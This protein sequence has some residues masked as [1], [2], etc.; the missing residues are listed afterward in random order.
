VWAW[1]SEKEQR[2]FTMSF[3]RINQ[4]KPPP[5]HRSCRRTIGAIAGSMTMDR[6]INQSMQLSRITGSVAG[7]V[8][9]INQSISGN[10][11]DP[12]PVE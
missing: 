7:S 5:E 2:N 9:R 6:R 3:D 1:Q 12:S 11:P 10:M 4:P 8:S